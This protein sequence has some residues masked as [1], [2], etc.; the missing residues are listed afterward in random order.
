EVLLLE[1]TAEA[2]VW[3]ALVRSKS[4]PERGERLELGEGDHLLFEAPLGEGRA[5]VRFAAG[6]TPFEL[7]ERRGHVPLPPYIRGAEDAPEDRARYQT[8]YAREKGA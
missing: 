7:A 6:T 8:V 1:P 5:R 3:E 4:V 2:G